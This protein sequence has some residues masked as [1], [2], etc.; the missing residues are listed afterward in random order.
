MHQGQLDLMDYQS[1]PDGIWKWV[2]HYQDHHNKLSYLNPLSSKCAREVALRLVDIF[3]L[4]GAPCILQMDNG[5]EFVAKVV[6]ELKLIWPGMA[7][8]HGKPRHPQSQGSVERANGDVHTMLS[9]WMTDNNSKNWALGLKFVQ[10]QKN[11][12]YHTT[13]KCTP[14][15]ATFGLE[16]KF[17]LNSSKIPREILEKLTEEEELQQ[18]V[19]LF[20]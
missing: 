16:F 5:R 11:N 9:L 18:V 1:M 6:E 10:M 7:I 3:T 4:I 15:Y 14:Y 13:I 8:V 12:S 19:D 17:A 20:I 2:M